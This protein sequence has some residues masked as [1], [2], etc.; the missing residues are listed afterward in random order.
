MERSPKNT[1]PKAAPAGFV[2]VGLVRVPRPGLAIAI[3]T[4]VVLS[5]LTMFPKASTMSTSSLVDW[6]PVIGPFL[7][8]VVGLL[9][10]LRGAAGPA[11]R[12]NVSLMAVRRAVHVGGGL[13][14]ARG[15]PCGRVLEPKRNGRRRGA[16]E[17]RARL[18]AERRAVREQRVA[19]PGLRQPNAGER[20]DAVDRGERRRSSKARVT[21]IVV[22]VQRNDVRRRCHRIAGLVENGHLQIW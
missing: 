20:R 1:S 13:R 22:E 21:R 14:R 8:A 16:V 19:G 18:P 2:L 11:A 15:H 3:V 12:Q 10:H 7:T 6:F 4:D 5:V 9:T 17:R